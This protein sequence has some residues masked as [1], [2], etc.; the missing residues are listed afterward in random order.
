M[1]KF[2]P[3]DEI[4]NALN[5]PRKLIEKKFAE[6]GLP[7]QHQELLKRAREYLLEVTNEVLNL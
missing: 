4:L 7:Y 1:G 2:V 3:K 5:I 6:P